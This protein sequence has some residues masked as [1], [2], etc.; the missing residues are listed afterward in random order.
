MDGRDLANAFYGLQGL[1]GDSDAERRIVSFLLRQLQ[2]DPTRLNS[3]WGVSMS[4]YGLQNMS[5]DLPDVRNLFRSFGEA[6]LS[7]QSRGMEKT[8]AKHFILILYALK[9]KRDDSIEM[10]S[11]LRALTIAG[12]SLGEE[13]DGRQFAMA[14]FG[15]RQMTSEF[16]EVRELLALLV[17]KIA[18]TCRLDSQAVGNAMIG[19]RTM[20]SEWPEVRAVLRIL[21]EKIGTCPQILSPQAVSM[22]LFGLQ[23]MSSREEEVRRV[24]AALEPKVTQAASLSSH[25][26]FLM[27]YLA[28][29]F[30]GLRRCS[31]N[32][33][34]VCSIV[35]TLAWQLQA[36]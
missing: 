23:G 27:Q 10:R 8:S 12:R 25:Q 22:A 34:M 36:M 35:R 1:T 11:I 19:L 29:G 20:K 3:Y 6:L 5:G 14:L 2:D 15:L 7:I 9:E 13:L 4:I 16:E 21:A 32:E 17:N 26:P 30:F 31:D 18:P 28:R 33:R 24:L